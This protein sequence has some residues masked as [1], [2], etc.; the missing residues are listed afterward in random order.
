M[1][2][3]VRNV[4]IWRARR[5]ELDAA[6]CLLQE[7]FEVVGVMVRE[8]RE[9]FI[10]EYFAEERAFWLARLDG[11]LAGCVGLRRLPRPEELEPED[12]KCA[13]IKRM[14]VREGFRGRGIAQRLMEAAEN[15]ARGE[16]YARIYLDTTTEMAAAA[17]LYERNG[18][19]RCERYNENPQAAIFMRKYLPIDR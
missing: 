11:E 16:G 13:E 18:F 4:G 19:V 15:F 12:V 14:Y 1:S 6:F 9:K 10:E 2:D 8:D 3:G 7:Y 17:R 5:E